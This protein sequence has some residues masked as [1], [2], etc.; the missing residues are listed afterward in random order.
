MT[1]MAPTPTNQR[2]DDELAH[3]ELEIE[4]VFDDDEAIDFTDDRVVE[5]D[6]DAF[7]LDLDSLTSL[8]GPDFF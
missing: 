7:D 8:D 5:L 1:A 6:E 4:P 3:D 2:E